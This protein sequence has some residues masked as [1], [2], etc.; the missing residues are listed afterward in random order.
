M[1]VELGHFALLIA[2]AAALLQAFCG[3][4]GGQMRNISFANMARG[5]SDVA[6]IAIVFS[7]LV[8]V[9]SYLVSDFS[10]K[11][12]AEN[13]H[14]LKPLIYKIAG[15]WGNHEG[16]MLLWVLVGAGYSSSL[17]HFAKSLA[18]GLKSRAM[19]V[20]GSI[21]S[22]VIGYVVFASNPFLRLEEPPLQG[23]DLNPLLQDPALAIH[24]PFLYLGYVGLS[25]V[26][27]LAV[28]GLLEGKIDAAW[29]R[30]LRPW[31]LVSWVFLTIGILLGSYW[32]YYE[33]GWGGWWFWDPV[34]NASF[35]PWLL[36][37][38]LLHSAIVTEKRGALA[39]WTVLLSILAFSLSL[40]GTF[41]V[42]SGV[43]T[44]VHAFALDPARGVWILII[45][46][47]FTGGGLLLYG[48]KGA[49]MASD[50]G[51]FAP[52]SRE[53]SLIL[54]NLF[55]VVACFTILVGTLYPLLG[56]AIYGR[57]ISVGAPYFNAVF[58]PL[59]SIVLVILPL[60][61]LLSWKRADLLATSKKLIWVALAA[62]F[63]GLFVA[64]FAKNK[65]MSAVGIAIGIW[66]ILAAIFEVSNRVGFGKIP[67]LQ[68]FV[69]LKHLR[70]MAIGMF[71]AHLG[72]GIF[73]ISAVVET[74]FKTETTQSVASGE[75][76]VFGDYEIKLQA[77]EAA[78]GPNYYGDRAVL[79]I[80]RGTETFLLSPERRYY[81][82][83]KMP[84]SEVARHSRGLSELYIAL[85]EPNIVDGRAIWTLRLYENPM[86]GWLFG[87]CFVIAL[88]GVV[89]LL[90]RNLRIG[91]PKANSKVRT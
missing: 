36:A 46:A 35:M 30:W 68:S 33:L 60:A 37:T 66:L 3:L 84:T 59:M 53:S 55:L 49:K 83:A 80:K 2:F 12:V 38:A 15:T 58:T 79:S 54:N 11:N 63:I 34:E 86:I 69:R 7:F 75:T 19:G 74:S 65:P 87:G 20:Q 16:S 6:L 22:S 21:A 61:T 89:S 25:L 4:Y 52:I 91:A 56:E 31:A 39:A 70:L 40:L 76:V 62:I 14:S 41:L 88:G 48:L 81:P 18:F 28:A 24:P 27:S 77:I 72:V 50:K 26:Y 10:L 73:T 13:S 45:L 42:R 17:A 8:L 64:F 9:Y 71:L 44:S 47:F 29:A 51:L 1:I 57:A 67:L 23:N 90:D 82:A 85:G 5:A 78:E 43:I 32:A